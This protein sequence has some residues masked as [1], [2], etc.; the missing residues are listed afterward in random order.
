M[1]RG[2]RRAS[3]QGWVRGSIHPSTASTVSTADCADLIPFSTLLRPSC[4]QQMHQQCLGDCPCGCA[5]VRDGRAARERAREA[6]RYSAFPVVPG[7]PVVKS[8]HG[9]LPLEPFRPHTAPCAP[10]ASTRIACHLLQP[11]ASNWPDRGLTPIQSMHRLQ[12]G[13]RLASG[14]ST[15]AQV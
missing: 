3:D 1:D 9:P 15:L 7:V 5:D 2:S 13:L 14:C 4:R 6:V 11:L 8:R 12:A 10:S